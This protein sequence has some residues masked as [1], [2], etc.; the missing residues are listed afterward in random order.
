MGSQLQIKVSLELEFG[1]LSEVI[2]G[3]LKPD[4]QFELEGLKLVSR[5]DEERVVIDIDC[6]RGPKSVLMT[7]DDLFTAIFTAGSICRTVGK[8]MPNGL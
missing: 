3:A 1:E 8:M 7:L 5:L 2:Y 6:S 4:E